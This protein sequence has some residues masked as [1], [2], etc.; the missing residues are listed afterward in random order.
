[1]RCHQYLNILVP[2]SNERRV[3]G[4]K[5][6]EVVMTAPQERC[7][8]HGFPKSRSYQFDLGDNLPYKEVE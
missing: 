6:V 4:W 3:A 5:H 2:N 1:M 7:Y 8:Q